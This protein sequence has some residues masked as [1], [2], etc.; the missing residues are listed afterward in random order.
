MEQLCLASN[1]VPYQLPE[2]H[3]R[4][5]YILDAIETT[6]LRLQAA[7]SS[8]R[9]DTGEGGKQSNFEATVAFITPEDPVARRLNNRKR[10]AASISDVDVKKGHYL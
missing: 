8:V 5:G 4:V 7:L 6:D 1:H 10:G 3:T 9:A 2:E